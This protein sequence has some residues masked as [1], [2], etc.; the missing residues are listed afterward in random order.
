[1]NDVEES[2]ILVDRNDRPIGTKPKLEAHRQG[3][4][5]RAFSVLIHDSQGLMLL[6]K[7]HP[8]KYHSGGLW[9]NA[10]CGHPR[11]DEGT[12]AAA[13]RRLSEEM[14][15]SCP[16]HALGSLVYRAEVGGG[17]IEHEYVHLIVGRWNG[18]VRPDPEEAEAF[19][20][21]PLAS[22]RSELAAT[23]ERFTAW[24]RLYLNELGASAIE[25]SID[26]VARQF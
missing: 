13:S 4:L 19:A 24:F 1:M 22:V 7:R 20:W 3:D 23:P 6:Q 12:F 25:P 17:L 21:R 9:T 8:S 5:H 14:G 10:C 18:A 15:F 26:A 11:P 2:V 16:L